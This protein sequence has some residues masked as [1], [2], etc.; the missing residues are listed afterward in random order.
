MGDSIYYNNNIIIAYT[1][2]RQDAHQLSSEA[3]NCM[4]TTIILDHTACHG[5]GNLRR[6]T[7]HLTA[8][9]NIS[10]QQSNN[11]N[12]NN[13]IDENQWWVGITHVVASVWP[14]QF[15]VEEA[16]LDWLLSFL[17]RFVLYYYVFSISLL[18]LLR[19]YIVH[20]VEYCCT[21]KH[22]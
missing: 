10:T 16:V 17:L 13:I 6:I 21:V 7:N 4:H 22:G 11:N 19:Y 20:K 8:F 1:Y 12:H 5:K 9:N 2:L 14:S 15:L 18:F 3:I